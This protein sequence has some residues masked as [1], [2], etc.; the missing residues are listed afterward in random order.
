ME[1]LGGKRGKGEEGRKHERTEKVKK[2]DQIYYCPIFTK[3]R[4]EKLELINWSVVQLKAVVWSLQY[5]KDKDI[6]WLDKILDWDW[7]HFPE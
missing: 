4:K 6:I 5:I 2:E 7:R 3:K 1:G